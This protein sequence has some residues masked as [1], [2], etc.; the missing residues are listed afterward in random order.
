MT[1]NLLA[2]Y[3]SHIGVVH[4]V[5]N[6]LEEKSRIQRISVELKIVQENQ[7][8][9]SSLVTKFEVS[10]QRLV[11]FIRWFEDLSWDLG[12]GQLLPEFDKGIV[13]RIEIPILV[14]RFLFDL[15]KIFDK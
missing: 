5:I 7:R 10:S 13:Y 6:E 3:E 4:A 1:L 2:I 15:W 8:S 11:H 9:M 12:L 14:R